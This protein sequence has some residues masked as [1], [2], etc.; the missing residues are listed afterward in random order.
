M[1]V[2][3]QVRYKWLADKGN[4]CIE[5]LLIVL[6]KE[7]IAEYVLNKHYHLFTRKKNAPD[8][9]NFSKYIYNIK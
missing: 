3:G 6:S 7:I 8:K 9:Q 2:N 1:Y 4:K 5:K